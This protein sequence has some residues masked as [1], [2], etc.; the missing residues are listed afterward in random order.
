MLYEGLKLILKKIYGFSSKNIPIVVERDDNTIENMESCHDGR[1]IVRCYSNSKPENTFLKMISQHVMAFEED[2]GDATT[3]ISLLICEL[4]TLGKEVSDDDLDS[5]LKSIDKQTESGKLNQWMKT[6]LKNDKSSD[7]IVKIFNENKIHL[8]I[9]NKVGTE[10][11]T[12][13][14]DKVVGYEFKTD[15]EPIFLIP[16]FRHVAEVEIM[17][18]KRKITPEIYSA[19]LLSSQYTG[20]RL[21]V[22]C[23]WYDSKVE[24]MMNAQDGCPVVLIRTPINRTYILDDLIV[25]LGAKHDADKNAFIA[26]GDLKISEKGVLVK[27]YNEV[28]YKDLDEYGK[29]IITSAGKNSTA[30][31]IAKNRARRIMEGQITQLYISCPTKERMTDLHAM[32][33]D[34]LSS[35]RHT[36][37]KFIKGYMQWHKKYKASHLNLA[38]ERVRECFNLNNKPEC[39]YEDAYDSTNVIKS[40]II[41]A[42]KFNNEIMKIDF[43]NGIR[44]KDVNQ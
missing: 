14:V 22:I 3:F 31:L 37:D 43:E 5:V 8:V 36:D 13:D 1:T 21:F 19:H 11:D 44:I 30:I 10:K 6:V 42:V 9:K 16:A 4:L 25:M 38:L 26:V 40:A 23:D 32:I 18:D 35:I 17:I 28:S 34:V 20:R 15:I 7:D 29:S 24:S 33:T 12:F 2:F 27:P 39:F 41:R